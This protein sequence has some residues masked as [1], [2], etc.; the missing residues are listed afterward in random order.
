M[1]GRTLLATFAALVTAISGLLAGPGVAIAVLALAL[2][3]YVIPILWN[4][5]AAVPR[6]QSV[7][8]IVLFVGLAVAYGWQGLLLAAGS[9]VIAA[10][11]WLPVAVYRPLD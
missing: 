7:P 8:Y 9:A 5:D 4:S 2:N 11:L 6:T 10:V 1:N 3:V